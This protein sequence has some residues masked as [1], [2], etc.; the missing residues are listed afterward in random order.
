MSEKNKYIRKKKKPK[1]GQCK[2]ISID[3]G[4][5]SQPPCSDFMSCL[6]LIPD[7]KPGDGVLFLFSVSSLSIPQPRLWFSASVYTETP[8]ASHLILIDHV[9]LPLH[10]PDLVPQL[11]ILDL[12]WSSHVIDKKNKLILKEK[13]SLYR[14]AE[15]VEAVFLMH[16][17]FFY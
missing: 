14:G 13:C 12:N 6:S 2:Q 7:G 8:H 1:P 3:N 17:I 9:L 4:R 11:T 15:Q 16:D 5:W 10:E